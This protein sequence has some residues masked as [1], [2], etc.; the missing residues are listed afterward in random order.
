MFS[1]TKFARKKFAIPTTFNCD[2]FFFQ[3]YVIAYLVFISCYI[4][5]GV[6]GE[7]KILKR[8]VLSKLPPRKDQ[9]DHF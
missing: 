9:L 6:W 2:F 4:E 8:R 3:M 1:R 7:W 5:I